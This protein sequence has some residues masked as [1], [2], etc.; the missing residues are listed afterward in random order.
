[1]RK[2]MDSDTSRTIKRSIECD[3]VPSSIAESNIEIIT[4]FDIIEL[5]TLNY[6]HQSYNPLYHAGKVDFRNSSQTSQS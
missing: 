6:E 5:S 1:M 4:D 2:N 3:I